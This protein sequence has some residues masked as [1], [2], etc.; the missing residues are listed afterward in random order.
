[1]LVQPL[2]RIGKG[3]GKCLPATLSRIVSILLFAAYF[4]SYS[5]SLLKVQSMAQSVNLD[6]TNKKL[7][8]D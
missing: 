3:L 1:M 6:N 4:L 8:F 7:S 5:T 2:P